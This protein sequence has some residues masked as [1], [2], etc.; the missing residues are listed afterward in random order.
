M[1]IYFQI[2][3][4]RQVRIRPGAKLPGVKQLALRK[5]PKPELV[6]KHQNIHGLRGGLPSSS[7]VIAM[8]TLSEPAWKSHFPFLVL[9][10]VKVARFGAAESR[11]K[12]RKDGLLRFPVSLTL[13]YD[14]ECGTT[15]YLL[16]SIW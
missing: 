13:R 16:L 7:V 12:Q 4:E 1:E 3:G 8:Q 11:T 14:A 10:L 5:T 2:T 9:K 15:W 6:G